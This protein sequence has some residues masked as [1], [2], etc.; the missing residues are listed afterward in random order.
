MLEFRRLCVKRAVVESFT[1]SSVMVREDFIFPDTRQWLVCL[2]YSFF[3]Y[4][5]KIS[6][7]SQ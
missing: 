2:F 6:N 1:S 3:F 4:C 7:A 5:Q